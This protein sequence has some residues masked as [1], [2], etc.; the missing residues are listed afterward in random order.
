MTKRATFTEATLTRAIRAAEKQGKV[1]LLLPAGIA[2]VDPAVIPQNAASESDIDRWF[3][4]N[5]DDHGQGR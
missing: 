2:F 5:G 1:A 3:R 4:E